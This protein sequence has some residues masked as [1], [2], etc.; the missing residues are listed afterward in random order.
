M[1]KV[2]SFQAEAEWKKAEVPGYSTSDCV[3]LASPRLSFLTCD[4]HAASLPPRETMNVQV[5]CTPCILM[6]IENVSIYVK[7]RCASKAK[8]QLEK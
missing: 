5:L 7:E 3:N 2:G 6:P 1:S 4:L 8:S